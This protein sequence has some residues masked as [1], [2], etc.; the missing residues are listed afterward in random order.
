MK[1]SAKWS[2]AF[3]VTRY[4]HDYTLI[5]RLDDYVAFLEGSKRVANE[6]ERRGTNEK[7]LELLESIS[8]NGRQIA[9]QL[10][11]VIID[12]SHFQ[13]AEK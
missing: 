6:I 4:G 3:V 8:K 5:R 12:D 10:M 9:V 1:I 13:D 2:R 11:S 7:N